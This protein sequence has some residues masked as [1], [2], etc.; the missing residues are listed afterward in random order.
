MEK[1]KLVKIS[2]IKVSRNFRN[3]V[4]SP[5]KMN[6]YRD[7]YCLGK[8]SKHSY[9]KC[10]GQVKPIILNENNMIVDGYIQYLVM[11]EMDEEYCYCCVEHKLVVYTLIDGVHTNGNSKEYT[12]R[13][14]DNTNW[15]EFKSKISYGDLIWVRTSNGIAPIIV[16]NITTIEAIEGELSG[17]ERIAKKDI[18][19]GELWKSIEIDEKVLIK[20]SVSEE[21]IPA[22]Y[23]GLTYEGKPTVWNNGG[24]SWTTDMIGIPKYIR[25]PGSVS[26][27]KHKDHMTNLLARC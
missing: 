17:L 14:P 6:R 20:N 2:D 12:W 10:A 27:G 4:P 22:H 25:L 24:T 26:F 7:A 16:T 13:V 3:S 19:K 15:N 5:E 1:L 9:E 18:M 21:W 11:K 8:D 23:A